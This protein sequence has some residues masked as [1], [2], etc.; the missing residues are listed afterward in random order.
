MAL[1]V[2]PIKPVPAAVSSSLFLTK[3]MSRMYSLKDKIN[4]GEYLTQCPKL[5]LDNIG[6]LISNKS[7]HRIGIYTFVNKYSQCLTN[8]YVHY[9]VRPHT[10]FHTASFLS[11]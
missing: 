10:I 1:H 11:E 6:N 8:I 2:H 4:V 3:L 7:S 5:S 9:T